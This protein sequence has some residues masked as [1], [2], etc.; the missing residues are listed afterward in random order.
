ML[1]NRQLLLIFAVGVLV[2]II[3]FIVFNYTTTSS[4]GGHGDISVKTLGNGVIRLKSFDVDDLIRLFNHSKIVFSQ[5][6]SNG[7]NDSSYIVL[8]RVGEE[9]IN[10]TPVYRVRIEAVSADNKSIAFL[11]IAKDFSKILMFRSGGMEYT[12][13]TAEYY[14]RIVLSAPSFVLTAMQM[15][16]LFDINVS[17]GRVSATTLYW[18]IT[19]FNESRVEINGKVYTVITGKAVKTVN[20]TVEREVLFRAVE[21]DGEWYLLYVK[22]IKENETYTISVKE[23]S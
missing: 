17:D 7:T 6:Y 8:D 23:L 1:G 10:G 20:S 5:V 11:W 16:V 13:E 19:S 21:I 14:G 3:G 15:S 12:N 22:V 9:E 18:N 2:G 4:R